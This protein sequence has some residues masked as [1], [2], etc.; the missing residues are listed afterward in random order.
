MVLAGCERLA[1]HE[2]LLLQGMTMGTHYHVNVLNQERT[3]KILP[4]Q[5]DLQRSIQQQ[6]ERIEMLMSNWRAESE[7]PRFNRFEVG[8]PFE[9]ASQ[10]YTVLKLAQEVNELTKGAFDICIS[11]LV[12]SSRVLR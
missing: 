3:G 12:C 7:I 8:V 11:S 5:T 6:L 9:I 2:Q 4:N 1:S 10:T